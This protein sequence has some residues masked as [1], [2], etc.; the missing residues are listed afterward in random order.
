VAVLSVI[1]EETI[2]VRNV[3]G[4]GRRLDGKPYFISDATRDA[5][6][7]D[8]V[9]RETGRT[10]I[11]SGQCIRDV[12]EHW[13]VEALILCGIAGGIARHE[14]VKIGDVIIPDYIHY[15]SF[16]KLS[17]DGTQR[18]YIPYDHPSL[19]LHANYAAPLQMD[20]SWIT[21]EVRN[22][23]PGNRNPDVFAGSLI[24]GDKV[25]GDPTSEEQSALMQEYD[26]AIALDME[27]V[28]L[29]RA[30]ASSR[31]NPQYNPRLLIVRGISDLVDD[32]DNM[33]QRDSN[34]ANSAAVAAMFACRVVADILA[35][36]PDP[37]SL[38][39]EPDVN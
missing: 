24:A 8:I 34:K 31:D 7:P 27:S 21:P 12:I 5:S 35:N 33:A 17:K 23:M 9:M 15:C 10:N 19:S 2:A 14:N 6:R 25:Y 22:L 32:P 4:L 30:V 13:Q 36:E 1:R 18:R 39:G 26:E 29:C 28:G 37:R 20:S 38:A 11:V 16:A 3:F